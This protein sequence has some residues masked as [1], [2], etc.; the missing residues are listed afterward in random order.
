MQQYVALHKALPDPEFYRV[1]HG[2]AGLLPAL[3]CPS[4]TTSCLTS[5]AITTLMT[6]RCGCET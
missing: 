2:S 5:A 4:Y 6:G 3:S 1:I